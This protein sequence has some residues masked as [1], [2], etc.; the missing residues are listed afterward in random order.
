[1]V[2]FFTVTTR[3]KI[4]IGLRHILPVYPFLFVIASRLATVQFQR[5]WLTP[6]L[7]GICLVSTATSSLRVAPHQLSYFNEFVGGPAEGT[8]I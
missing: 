6:V 7:L 4:N 1:V 5:R 2:I 3:A 8:V